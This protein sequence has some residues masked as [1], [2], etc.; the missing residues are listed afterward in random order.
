[1][2]KKEL[3]I[4]ADG[5]HTLFIPEL[6]ET[7][8]STHGAIQEAKHV[9]INAGLKCCN[10]ET[11]SVLEIGFGTGLNAFLTFLESQKDRRKL[12]YT[13]L[14]AFPLELDLI[15]ELNYTKQLSLD[16][17]DEQLFN[18]I[19]EIEWGNYHEISSR[20]KLKKLS[21][22][23]ENFNPIE[24]YDLIYF[25]AFGPRVQP[26]MWT[27]PIFEKMYNCLN[28]NGVLVTYCAKGTVKRGLKEVGFN[29]ES[30]P[31]PPGKREMTRAQKL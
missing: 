13:S 31:G 27:I 22:K 5:S 1:M 7:Y 6:D 24:K 30:L 12:S 16:A 19:H 18:K 3:K 29:V 9:F 25:D 23:L 10:L 26:E 11:L 4:T 8:H 15:K 21:E 28:T 2:D 14:E 17:Q 20:F